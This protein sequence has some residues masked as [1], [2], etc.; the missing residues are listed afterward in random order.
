MGQ[1]QGNMF[2]T[3]SSAIDTASDMYVTFDVLG[4]NTSDSYS[5]SFYAIWLEA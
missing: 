1:T 4:G 5:L 2:M 3:S